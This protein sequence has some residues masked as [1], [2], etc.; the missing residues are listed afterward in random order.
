MKKV[1][2]K[3]YLKI[4]LFEK[5]DAVCVSDPVFGADGNEDYGYDRW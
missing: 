1:Y 5:T 4:T 3:A 2:D